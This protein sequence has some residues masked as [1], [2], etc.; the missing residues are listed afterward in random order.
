V[1]QKN[2]NNFCPELFLVNSPG[3]TQNF[4]SGF[5]PR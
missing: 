4:L 5:F 2:L 1:G 3:L